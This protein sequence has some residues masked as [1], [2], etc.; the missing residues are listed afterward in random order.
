M[1][2]NVPKKTQTEPA[3]IFN[4]DKLY[5]K[6]ISLEVPNAPKIFLNTQ[7]PN[8]ELNISFN[9]ESLDQMTFQTIVHAQITAKIE[10]DI[11]FIIEVDQVGVFRMQNI[12]VDQIEILQ[13]IECPNI[14]F[15]YLRETISDLSIRAGFM[16]VILSPVNFAFLYQQKKASQ[17]NVISNTIN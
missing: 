15:P 17:T 6:D 7:K 14:L 5:I 13:N 12:P 8:I 3:M 2:Q 4:I 11:M 16:P 10:T 9:S 1:S